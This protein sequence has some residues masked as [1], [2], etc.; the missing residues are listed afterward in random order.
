MFP[1]C[2]EHQGRVVLA[3]WVLRAAGGVVSSRFKGSCK[4]LYGHTD[5]MGLDEGSSWF[6][7]VRGSKGALFNVKGPIGSWGLW[8]LVQSPRDLG[9]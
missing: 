6:L 8:F 1:G 3:I 2:Y 5:F 9:S 4:L 7:K